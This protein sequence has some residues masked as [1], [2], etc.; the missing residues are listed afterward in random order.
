MGNAVQVDVTGDDASLKD[1]LKDAVQSISGLGASVNKVGAEV[2][3]AGDAAEKGASF[4]GL[5]L[6]LELTKIA[7]SGVTSALGSFIG[8]IKDGIAES[9]DWEVSIAKIDAVMKGNAGAVGL[10]KDA[11]LDLTQEMARNTRFNESMLRSAATTLLTF[12]NVKG[13]NFKEVLSLAGDLAEIMGGDLTSATQMLGRALENPEQGMMM[14]RRAGIILSDEQKA[15]I[16]TLSDLGQAQKAQ[17]LLLDII[18]GKVGG[19]AEAI[20]KTTQ[21]QWTIFKNKIGE[22]IEA[23][24]KGF[25]PVIQEMLPVLAEITDALEFG[26]EKFGKWVGVWVKSGEAKKII[27]STLDTIRETL[28]NFTVT[29]YTVVTNIGKIFDIMGTSIALSTVKIYESFRYC[30]MEEIPSVFK[31]ALDTVSVFGT[32]FLT[33]LSAIITNITENAAQIPM[34]LKNIA[35]GDNPLK[36]VKLTLTAPDIDF[37]LPKL[38]TKAQEKG[39]LQKALEKQLQDLNEEIA[40]AGQD[41]NEELRKRLKELAEGKAKDIKKINE[42][43]AETVVES[44]KDKDNKEAKSQTGGTVGLE[45][46]AKR[47]QSSTRSAQD[48]AA[49]AIAKAKQA[50]QDVKKVLRINQIGGLGAPGAAA[51]GPGIAQGFA[52]NGAGKIPTGIRGDGIAPLTFNF[53]TSPKSPSDNTNTSGKPTTNPSA[54]QGIPTGLQIEFGKQASRDGQTIGVLEKIA[55]N[56]DPRKAVARFA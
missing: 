46:L 18:R 27:T 42:E 41:N 52:G 33:A 24:G 48:A 17:A 7:I 53:K 30:F 16:K 40:K 6:A 13:D 1:A 49:G 36:D 35:S 14:L 34:I 25:L 29:A 37:K 28:I 8:L 47:I 3:R 26:A 50:Q 12:H 44:N 55:D 31:F 23:L 11:I 56:T 9:I 19:A 43:E 21:G 2:T 15:Q 51:Q 20:G 54:P 38:N 22:V 4:A 10:T 5:S 39:E 32:A 45:E